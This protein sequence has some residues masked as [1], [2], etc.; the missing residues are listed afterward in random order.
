[1]SVAAVEWSCD[2][3]P[4]SSRPSNFSHSF[5]LSSSFQWLWSRHSSDDCVWDF[6]FL[7]L[8]G[9][10]SQ[11]VWFPNSFQRRS[12]E[13]LL[14]THSTH[15]PHFFLFFFFLSLF[16]HG[17]A[18]RR[19]GKRSWGENKAPWWLYAAKSN[20]NRRKRRVE[21][22]QR[23]VQISALLQS[24]PLFSVLVK[25]TEVSLVHRVNHRNSTQQEV[26]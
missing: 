2:H 3:G 19:W 11:W 18:F 13:D 26:H 20:K 10:Q 12:R 7:N 4:S 6:D 8:T 24:H 25:S 1:M 23:C 9:S 15:A 17:N 22:S 21:R 14:A 5:S 16:T